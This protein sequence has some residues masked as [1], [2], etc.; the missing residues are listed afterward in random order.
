MHRIVPLF[1][2]ALFVFFCTRTHGQ[3]P[4][5]IVGSA[6]PDVVAYDETGAPHRF[7]DFQGKYVVFD[8]STSWCY[9]S[10]ELANKLAKVKAR[11]KENGTDLVIY[12][13]IYEDTLRNPVP[14]RSQALAWKNAFPDTDVVA[15][16]HTGLGNLVNVRLRQAGRALL[17][18]GGEEEVFPTYAIIAPD[19]KVQQINQGSPSADDLMAQFLAEQPTLEPVVTPPVGLISESATLNVFVGKKTGTTRAPF[20][21]ASAGAYVVPPLQRGTLSHEDGLGISKEEAPGQQIWTLHYDTGPA[22]SNE[23]LGIPATAPIRFTIPRVEWT[24]RRGVL[25]SNTAEVYLYDNVLPASRMTAPVSYRNGAVEVGPFE[26]GSGFYHFRYVQVKIS[27]AQDD[28]RE[29]AVFA[30]DETARLLFLGED[31]RAVL[32]E[33]W[34]GIENAVV[35]GAQEPQLNLAIQRCIALWRYIQRSKDPALT[36]RE[37]RFYLATLSQ[38]KQELRTQ[39]IALRRSGG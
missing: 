9:P 22:E 36:R 37:K 35:L 18:A 17:K 1:L 16:L 3:T 29:L 39:K 7:T 34:R 14:L 5:W 4:E 30:A 13:L 19:G 21:D 31:E 32:I 28:P 8:V 26:V 15:A 38:I 11:L 24:G 6:A 33:Q 23:D 2:T 25:A 10:F 12:T 20:F 27:W